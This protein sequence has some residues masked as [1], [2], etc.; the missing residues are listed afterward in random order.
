MSLVYRIRAP[1][2]TPPWLE[3]WEPSRPG[4]ALCHRDSEGGHLVGVCDELVFK[5]AKRWFPVGDT[6]WEVGLV[7]GATFEPGDLA[8]A[9]VLW[10]DARAV[11]DLKGRR[12]NAPRILNDRGERDFRIAY[13]PDWLPALTDEQ[14]RALT[15]CKTA[16]EEMLREGESQLEMRVAC[17]W[18]AELLSLTHHLCPAV[19]AVLGLLDDLLVPETLSASTGMPSMEAHHGN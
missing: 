19:F 8:R 9:G 2:A 3:G 16:R 12:W 10:C 15:I 1:I 13:G 5:P 14:E 4:V 17:Q 6:G 7:P 18:V 11:A